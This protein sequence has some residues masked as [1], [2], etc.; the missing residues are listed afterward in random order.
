MESL[1]IEVPGRLPRD[2]LR[3]IGRDPLERLWRSLR[4]GRSVMSGTVS[5]HGPIVGGVWG[6]RM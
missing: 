6:L 2:L 3:G 5:L 4:V 1:P